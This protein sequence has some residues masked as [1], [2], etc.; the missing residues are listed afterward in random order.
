MPKPIVNDLAALR[1]RFAPG[2]GERPGGNPVLTLCDEVERLRTT[3]AVLAREV[4]ALR[5]ELQHYREEG[6][7]VPHESATEGGA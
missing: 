4:A 6:L 1:M 7:I 3:G 5:E 2:R